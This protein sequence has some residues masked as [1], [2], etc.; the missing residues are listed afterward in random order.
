M[1]LLPSLGLN[2]TDW[3]ERNSNEDLIG[4]AQVRITGA[5]SGERFFDCLRNGYVLW[6]GR[7][8]RYS[9]AVSRWRRLPHLPGR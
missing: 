6:H 4:V 7:K 8:W 9:D 3:K 1:N 2:R 5:A